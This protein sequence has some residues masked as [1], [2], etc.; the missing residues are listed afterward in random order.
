VVQ[1]PGERDS[2]RYIALGAGA[3]I[4]PWNFPLAIWRV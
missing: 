1:L 4:S 2:L 3:V